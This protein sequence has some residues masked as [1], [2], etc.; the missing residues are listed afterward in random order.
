MK[1]MTIKIIFNHFLEKENLLTKT[2]KISSSFIS[3]LCAVKKGSR[4]RL[5]LEN[6]NIKRLLRGKGLFLSL[7]K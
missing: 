6:R 1:K 4:M 5:S 2:N 7:L 3:I